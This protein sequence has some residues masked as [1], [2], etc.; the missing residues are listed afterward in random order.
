MSLLHGSFTKETYNLIDPTNQSH[1]IPPPGEVRDMNVYT[2]RYIY[3]GMYM[4]YVHGIYMV[5]IWYING[6]YTME[7]IYVCIYGV[8]TR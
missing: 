5:Y 6:S 3:H 1:P 7:S 8:Y 2:C 4:V